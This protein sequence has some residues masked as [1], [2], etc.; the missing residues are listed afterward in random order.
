MN[1]QTLPFSPPLSIIAVIVIVIAV[2]IYCLARSSFCHV[3]GDD[4]IH[5]IRMYPDQE[6][7]Q[8]KELPPTIIEVRMLSYFFST[9]V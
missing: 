1:R 6:E 9:S 2:I 3:S 7:E 4:S 5:G 8:E